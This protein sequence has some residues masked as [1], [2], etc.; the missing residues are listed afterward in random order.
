MDTGIWAWRLAQYTH[1]QLSELRREGGPLADM[2][3]DELARRAVEAKG[4]G[5]SPTG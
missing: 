2:A 5:S 4:E 3:R 1:K